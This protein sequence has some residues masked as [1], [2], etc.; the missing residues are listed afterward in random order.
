MKTEPKIL[1]GY[2]ELLPAQQ[3][4]FNKMLKVIQDTFEL[5]GFAPLDTPA[6]ELSQ[7]L[8][9]KAGGETEKQ[10]Y[11]FTRGKND[12]CLRFDLTVP[13]ARYAAQRQNQLVFPFRRYQ[14]QKVWRAERPQN[15]RFREFYQCD[16]DII[17]SKNLLTD[18]E[19]LSVVY[20]VFAR[21]GFGRFT[22]KINN[23]KVLNGF[24][25]S[26]GIKDIAPVVR[27]I[28]K[29]EKQSQ[30]S[31]AKELANLELTPGAI[32]KLLSFVQICGTPDQIVN[33]LQQL[34]IS[35][36]Q[37]LQGVEELKTITQNVLDLGVSLA[38]FAID[39]KIARGLDYYTGTVY[40]T[41]LNDYPQIGSVCSGGRYDNLASCYT[42]RELPGVGAS[43]G[44][45]RLFDQLL[46]AEAIEAKVSTPAKVLVVSANPTALNQSVKVTQ[47]LRQA[48]I[49]TEFFTED[50]L[51]SKQLKYAARQGF[52]FVV[53]TG[54]REVGRG[55]VIVKNLATSVQN[56][57]K[58][59]DIATYIN[60]NQI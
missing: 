7:V 24:L 28:D 17:G 21:L 13:L 55:K 15:G 58:S 39:L 9:A 41:T 53:I 4:Q 26:V 23:R 35:D 31:I 45:T 50:S 33:N 48:N 3:I 27:I 2:M 19:I 12:L 38:N 37:F 46:K 18:A 8:L 29:L 36:Q 43:I 14:T 40:E 6:I 30:Q 59:T 16:I 20:Q 42:N 11:K 44:L 25:Q 60:N 47:I 34:N 56:E 5:C 57:V 22:I 52:E 51:L 10:I 32:K 49:A 54:M 1:A